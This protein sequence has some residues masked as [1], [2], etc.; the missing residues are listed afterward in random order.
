M[1]TNCRSETKLRNSHVLLVY[2]AKNI[3]KYTDFAA[4]QVMPPLFTPILR[5][6]LK[7]LTIQAF[8]NFMRS[9]AKAFKASWGTELSSVVHYYQSQ[10]QNVHKIPLKQER[11][12]VKHVPK[13]IIKKKSSYCG[14]MDLIELNKAKHNSH[15]FETDFV[16][17]FYKPCLWANSRPPTL[18]RF[19]QRVLVTLR[20]CA[21]IAIPFLYTIKYI[22][23]KACTRQKKKEFIYSTE[24]LNL[25]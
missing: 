11:T 22:L 12:K 4:F 17:D 9:V 8:Q 10:S 23:A 2:Y 6:L 18:T 16:H 3:I 15:Y 21:N 5:D 20:P 24:C 14:S 19:S 7:E 1:K 13:K 25:S